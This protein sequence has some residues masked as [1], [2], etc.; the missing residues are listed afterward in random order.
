MSEN[1]R[2][3]ETACRDCLS[4]YFKL[5]P[6]PSIEKRAA[7]LV[8]LLGACEESRLGKAEGWALGLVYLLANRDRRAVG[9]P[10]ALNAEVE[11]LFGVSM[12]TIRKRAAQVDRLL[13]I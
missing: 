13:T 2:E 11:E 7:R 8:R 5:Y 1:T 12:S 10:G 3:F 4:R 6:E 9:F